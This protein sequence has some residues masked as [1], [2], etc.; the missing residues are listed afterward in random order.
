MN[1][2]IQ[3]GVAACLDGVAPSAVQ[4][5]K[6]ISSL[7]RKVKSNNQLLRGVTQPFAEEEEGSV[8]TYEVTSYDPTVSASD[9]RSQIEY[10]SSSGLLAEH[11]REFAAEY[12]ADPMTNVNITTTTV[13]EPQVSSDGGIAKSGLSSGEIA[14]VVIGVVLFIT[15][16]VLIVG[17]TIHQE[18]V[19]YEIANRS[20]GTDD[21][22]RPDTPAPGP[23]FNLGHPSETV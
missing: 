6:L 21:A 20:P 10:A 14:G 3:H 11:L 18:K 15:L 7:S 13:T 22:H 8:L 16:C 2:T 1:L 4:N 9:L 23:D 12:G 19:A 5:I 17:Y